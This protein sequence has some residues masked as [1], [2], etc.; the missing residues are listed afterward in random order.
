VL[1]SVN[2][3]GL[4]GRAGRVFMLVLILP[5][6]FTEFKRFPI[7]SALQDVWWVLS[8]LYLIFVYPS[9]TTRP[10]KGV[11]RFEWYVIAIIILVPAVSS[12]SAW[13]V[14]GQPILWGF[15][16][17]RSI[18]GLASVLF[19]IRAVKRRYFTLAEIESALLILAWGTLCCYTLMRIFL[20]PQEYLAYPGFA[21]LSGDGYGFTFARYCITFGF[22]YYMFRGFRTGRRVYYVIAMI[23][24]IG[25]LSGGSWR[26]ESVVLLATIVILF[27]RWSKLRNF[28]LQMAGISLSLILIVALAWRFMPEM[29][30]TASG[31]FQDAI[32]VMFTG[33]EVSD[34]SANARIGESV[35]AVD[36]FLKHPVFGNGAVSNKW[37]GGSQSILGEY[38]YADDVGILGIL[39]SVGLFGIALY[40]W[41]L[42]YLLR[43]LKKLPQ[44][45]STPLMDGAK[46]VLL[47]NILITLT[48][49]ALMEDAGVTFFFIGLFYQMGRMPR[50]VEVEERLSEGFHPDG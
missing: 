34:A 18:A 49:P 9:W 20:N 30:A 31:R 36:G 13:M 38:F 25:S 48:S 28:V 35:I 40:G 16:A 50:L 29:A 22:F 21:G 17:T 45:F 14:F 3:S 4:K 7:L 11:S 47:S 12:L 1:E 10:F 44:G 26:A 6:V 23:L 32:T 24:I 5:M 2:H 27:Y 37:G 8:L 39:Y 43:A 41:Q 15:V 33:N 46:G 42:V 19:M